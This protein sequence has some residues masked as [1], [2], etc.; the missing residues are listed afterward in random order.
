MKE[1][2]L[3][4]VYEDKALIVSIKP[5]GV[6]TEGGSPNVTELLRANWGREAYVGLVHRLDTNTAGL[7]VAAKTP[8]AAAALSQLI[9]L[10]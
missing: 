10:F 9:F 7:M 6:F 3:K 2:V 5:A 8:Q 1:P 4:I